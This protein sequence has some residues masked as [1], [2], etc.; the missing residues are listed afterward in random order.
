[1]CASAYPPVQPKTELTGAVPSATS[2]GGGGSGKGLTPTTGTNLVEIDSQNPGTW[3]ENVF[4]TVDY[5][6]NKPNTFNMAATL[7]SI[8]SN[9]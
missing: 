6:T 2:S 1:V 8:T 5:M 7:Y 4:V 9:S 3:G